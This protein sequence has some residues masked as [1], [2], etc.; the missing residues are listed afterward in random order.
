MADAITT[1][2]EVLFPKPVVVRLS[3][4]RS[5]EFRGLEGGEEVETN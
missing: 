5:N 3:D 1:A 2:A 4:F